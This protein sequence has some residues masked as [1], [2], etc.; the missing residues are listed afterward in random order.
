MSLWLPA[1]GVL[2]CRCCKKLLPRRVGCG[3]GLC[4]AAVVARGAERWNP[5]YLLRLCIVRPV[6][7]A[8]AFA[9]H[10][11]R[12]ADSLAFNL[13]TMWCC[14]FSSSF[15]FAPN[16]TFVN[17]MELCFSEPAR[18]AAVAPEA[19]RHNELCVACSA[20]EM[21]AWPLVAIY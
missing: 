14:T 8:T 18:W 17:A 5:A 9:R 7:F 19:C 12:K 20:C 1:V 16:A 4:R 21:K 6:H 11:S 15:W 2:S 10:P 13:R 3:E